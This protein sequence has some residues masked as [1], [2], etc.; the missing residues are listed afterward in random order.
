MYVFGGG[1]FAQYDHI[2]RY[3]PATGVVSQV[4]SLPT[5]AS[6][7]AVASVGGT[8]YVVGGYDGTNWL[9]TILAWRPG[10]PPRV[11][12]HLPFG[13]R[14]AAIAADGG[15]LIVAGGTTPSGISD[16]IL[17]FNSA[18][19]KVLQ[20][21]R[22]PVALTHAS[23]AVV[24]GRILIIGGRR[25]LTGEQTS[26]ILAVDPNSGATRRV[27]QLPLP[28]S[29]ASTATIGKAVIVAGGESTD[30]TQRAV[31]ALTPHLS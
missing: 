27:G 12:A 23:A 9:D 21:G 28:L 11:V 2:L 14:Y 25:Q 20:I 30:G 13:L 8:A 6:D 3:D 18:T 22:L 4:G 10:S 19:G 26:S 17:T 1:Q 15:R 5:P 7:V 31:L 16:V 24:D 29:D